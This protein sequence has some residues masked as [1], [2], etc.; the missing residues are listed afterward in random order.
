MPGLSTSTSP[1]IGA[2]SGTITF[3][4]LREAVVYGSV[5]ASFNVEAFSLERLRSLDNAQIDARFAE[6]RRISQF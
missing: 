4:A 3:A 1:G 2:T 5:V 6:F